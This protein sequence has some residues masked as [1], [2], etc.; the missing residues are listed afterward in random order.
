MFLISMVFDP[1]AL[2]LGVLVLIILLWVNPEK[3]ASKTMLIGVLTVIS[4]LSFNELAYHFRFYLIVP[5]MHNML[6]PFSLL[7]Y[8]AAWLYVRSV[9]D[10]EYNYKKTDWLLLLPFL[11]FAANLMPY[12]LMPLAEKRAYLEQYYQSSQLRVSDGEGLLPPYVFHLFKIIWAVVFVVLIARL[13]S[14]F[15]K[16]ASQ[17]V[18]LENQFVLNWLKHINLM[19]L[20][21]IVIAVAATLLTPLLTTSF[22]MQDIGIGLF[23]LLICLHLFAR[24]SILYGLHVPANAS[25]IIL[26]AADL[27]SK[28]NSMTNIISSIT[29]AKTTEKEVITITDANTKNYIQTI[30]N[31]MT[32]SMPFLQ[33]GYTAH[34]LVIDTGI[35]KHI[36]ALIIKHE[37]GMSFKEFTNRKRIEYFIANFHQPAWSQ[38]TMEARALDCGF[39]S[40]I[41]FI[42]NFKDIMGT[43][44]SAYFNETK[45]GYEESNISTL[46]LSPIYNADLPARLHQ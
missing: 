46:Y 14:K 12:Y 35:P 31:L 33:E 41:T 3:T 30:E 44:P 39:A 22:N 38:Y 17:Q 2:L 28:A 34:N 23:L 11:L 24:P 4:L 32:S 25:S 43:T 8:P 6:I 9:I 19:L 27:E 16:E 5:W 21:L 40:R 13:L 18:L 29:V 37:Y 7:L 20:G 10:G 26:Q 42:R 36:L 45:T 15:K 1:T